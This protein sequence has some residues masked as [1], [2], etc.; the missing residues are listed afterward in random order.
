[1]SVTNGTANGKVTAPDDGFNPVLLRLKQEAEDEV[2]R[3][4]AELLE[5]R[6]ELIF[7]WEEHAKQRVKLKE[8]SV[9]E[10]LTAAQKRL[11]AELAAI[12][13]H[14]LANPRLTKTARG[15]AEM[16]ETAGRILPEYAAKLEA[17]TQSALTAQS[18]DGRT[19]AFS[20]AYA[21]RIGKEFVALT[22]PLKEWIT[23]LSAVLDEGR[24]TEVQRMEL[25]LR[26]TE[27]EVKYETAGQIMDRL[28][29]T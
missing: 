19:T 8:S 22:G 23:K 4:R 2:K 1:M 11:D 18:D 14:E 10:A 21:F 12:R 7:Q 5:V 27:L 20:R 16:L 3:L 6:N 24:L 13:Q 17:M 28:G 25:L 15:L 29:V 9:E 26:L